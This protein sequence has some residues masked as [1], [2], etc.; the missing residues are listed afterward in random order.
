MGGSL[1]KGKVRRA[2]TRTVWVQAGKGKKLIRVEEP[3]SERLVLFLQL[4]VAALICLSLIEI[5]H[6][7]MLRSFNW[8]VFAAVTGLIGTITGAFVSK[9]A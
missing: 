2:F 4:N 9:R 5:A 7:I 8:E 1:L 6:I 3:P